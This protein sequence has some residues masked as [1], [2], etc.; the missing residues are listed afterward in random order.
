M[1]AFFCVLQ[2]KTTDKSHVLNLELRSELPDISACVGKVIDKLPSINNG[3][4]EV[5]DKLKIINDII[6]KVYVGIANDK[7]LLYVKNTRNKLAHGE[8]RYSEACRD[9]TDREIKECVDA[10][11][12]YMK[13]VFNGFV[14]KYS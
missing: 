1:A 5:N 9:K 12:S 10:S 7:L 8:L 11:Y 14:Q 3:L 13:R 4:N 6:S 2:Y